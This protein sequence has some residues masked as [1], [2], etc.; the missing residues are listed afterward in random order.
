MLTNHPFRGLGKDVF[1]LSVNLAF[2]SPAVCILASFCPGYVVRSMMA[3]LRRGKL[4][5]G[6]GV[7][8]RGSTGGEFPK[9]RPPAYSVARRRGFLKKFQNKFA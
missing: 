5:V 4:A 9:C 2:A 1:K 8:S 7:A 3:T 6:S